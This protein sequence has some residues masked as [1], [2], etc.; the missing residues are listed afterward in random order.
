MNREEIINLL[1]TCEKAVDEQFKKI[2]KIKEHN[3]E[4]VLSAFQKN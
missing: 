3:Q 2:D 1:E 4:K